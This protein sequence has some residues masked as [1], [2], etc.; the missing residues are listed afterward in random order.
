MSKAQ[1]DARNCLSSFLPKIRKERASFPSLVRLDNEI[2]KSWR[3]SVGFLLL[4]RRTEKEGLGS[5][6]KEQVTFI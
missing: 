6:P 4:F 5:L 1:V 3:L 2:I